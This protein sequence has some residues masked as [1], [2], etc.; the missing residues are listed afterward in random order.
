RPS[1]PG[2]SSAPGDHSTPP[3]IRPASSRWDGAPTAT[4]PAPAVTDLAEQ[5]ET[6]VAHRHDC[7]H[8]RADKPLPSGQPRSRLE[9]KL[10]GAAQHLR[11][12]NCPATE[13]MADLLGI[14][15]EAVKTQ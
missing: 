6:A 7:G 12:A 14:G 3:R 9:P 11:N 1:P 13:A 2:A 15:A 4:A 8:R 5:Q 10:L